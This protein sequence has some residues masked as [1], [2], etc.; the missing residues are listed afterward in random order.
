MGGKLRPIKS[1]TNLTTKLGTGYL[2]PKL[3]LL[4]WGGQQ[5]NISALAMINFDVQMV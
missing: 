5:I 4:S 3:Q 1:D 2:M